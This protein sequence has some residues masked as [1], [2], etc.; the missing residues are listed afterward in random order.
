RAD[1]LARHLRVRP[2]GLPPPGCAVV[3]LDDVLTTGATA[4]AATARLAAAGR[5]VDVVVVLTLAD[6][7]AQRSLVRVGTVPG[8]PRHPC[9]RRDVA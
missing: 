2:R 6:R 1:N 7:R 4:R 8:A 3:L 9:G 5:P